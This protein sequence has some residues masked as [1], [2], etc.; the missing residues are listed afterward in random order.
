MVGFLIPQCRKCRFRALRISYTGKIAEG[1]QIFVDNAYPSELSPQPWRGG[2]SKMAYIIQVV[3]WEGIRQTTTG[4]EFKGYAKTYYHGSRSR[5]HAIR[6]A[7]EIVEVEKKKGRK[8]FAIVRTPD[9][10]CAIIAE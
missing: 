3:S 6:R 1:E 10:E 7:R 8:A 2:K 5:Q 9:A 4:G